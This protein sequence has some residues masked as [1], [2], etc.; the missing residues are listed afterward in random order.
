MGPKWRVAGLTVAL[1]VAL[2]VVG[3]SQGTKRL[4]VRLLDPQYAHAVGAMSA[5]Y[6]GADAARLLSA[7]VDILQSPLRLLRPPRGR[8]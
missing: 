2:Y 6:D 4:L 3:T 1:A 8:A 7:V 5:T